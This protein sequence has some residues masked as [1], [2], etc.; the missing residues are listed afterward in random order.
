MESLQPQPASG[1]SGPR[2]TILFDGGA[3]TNPGMGYGNYEVTSLGQVIQ[4]SREK[5]GD[6]VTNNQAE[7]LTLIIALEWL[8]NDLG[9]DARLA[10]LLVQGDSQLVLNQVSGKW[11]VKNEGL[12]PLK[13]RADDALQRFMSAEFVWQ[14]APRFRTTPRAFNSTHRP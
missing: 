3:V 2:F 9:P 13:R 7:Y 4:R 5:F 12:M 1:A 10:S 14:R 11:K 6:N 8:A